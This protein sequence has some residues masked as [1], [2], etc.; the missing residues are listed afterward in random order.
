MLTSLPRLSHL[1]CAAAASLLAASLALAEGPLDDLKA[2]LALP[3]AQRKPIESLPF[4][5]AAISRTDADHAGQFLF[6]DR[7]ARLKT[8]RA[9][10]WDAKSITIGDKTMKFDYR[11][12]GGTVDTGRPMFISMH[13]GGGAPPEVNDQ[14][15]RNQITLYQPE[16]GLYVAPRAPTDTWNLWHEGHIDG[17]FD[18]LIQDA[19]ALQG[20]DP[21]RVYLM[22]YSAGGDGVYQLAPRM[23]DRWAAAAMMAGH[24]NEASPLNLR[25]LPFIIQVGADDSAYNRNTVAA[26]WGKKLDELRAK[27]PEGYEHEV[28]LRAGMGH[29]MKKEDAMALPWMLQYLRSRWPTRVVWRQDDVTHDRLYWLAQKHEA[30]EQGTVLAVSRKEQVFTVETAEGVTEFSILLSDDLADLDLPITVMYQGKPLFEGKVTRTFADLARTLEDRGDPSFIYP[31][32][33]DIT[34]PAPAPAAGATPASR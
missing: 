32:H 16:E 7:V 26:E 29:W 24:P 5:A 19:V 2:W 28:Y 30:V 25:N 13:G 10:E 14:Q 33:V 8:E 31:A 12:F 23:A 34:I 22:G 4:G 21:D 9:A 20:V 3:P 17:L 11:V 18:R 1:L 27:D 15:W 6:Q